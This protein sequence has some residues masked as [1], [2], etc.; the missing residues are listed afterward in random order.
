MSP[1]RLVPLAL[2]TLWLLRAGREAAF[3]A[4]SVDL[5]GHLWMGWSAAHGPLTRTRLL[6]WPEGVDLMPVLGGWLDVAL[7][8]WLSPALGLI[9]AYNLVAALYLAVAGFGGAALARRCGAGAAAAAVAGLLL[10]LDGFVLHHLAGGRPEQ[11][12]LGFVALALAAALGCW[13]G[14]VRPL[15]C[16]LLGALVVFVSWE[17]TLTLAALTLLLTGLLAWTEPRE[18][19]WRRWL[20]AG[21]VA[22]LAAGPWVM[23]FLSRAGGVRAVD[24][25]AFALET[26]SR[27]SVGLLGWLQAGQVRPSWGALLALVLLPLIL[28]R[29]HRKAAALV[30]L[31]LLGALALALGP[32]PGL[33]GPGPPTLEPWGPFAAIQGLP[34]LGWFH[35]PDRL[36]V[37]WSLAAAVAAALWVRQVG[38]RHVLAGAGLAALLLG[39][40]AGETLSAGRWPRAM[41]QIERRAGPLALSELT[42]PG[43]LLDLP[44][45]AEPVNHLPYMLDQVTHGRPILF[46]MVLSHLD[47]DGPRRRAL[48]DPVLSWFVRL[49]EARPPEAPGFQPEDFSALHAQGFRFLVLHQ[50]GWPGDRWEMADAALREALGPPALSDGRAWQCWHVP[51]GST[52]NITP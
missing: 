25:G 5:A 43:A 21:G 38:Q 52:G 40:A 24:E 7:V 39:G 28:P 35:W 9:G 42:E 8:G 37:P 1:W 33:W 47:E 18:G 12:G 15:V 49:T 48:A 13:R 31:T 14:E 23:R 32:R 3:G 29:A 11:V 44:I 4:F 34:L 19:A 10:Q 6:N 17:L 26:A 41:Y 36:L 46:H 2:P 45:Q 20:G 50:P 51:G 16:G 22:A 30:G 27:A